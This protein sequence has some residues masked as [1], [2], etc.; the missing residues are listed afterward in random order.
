MDTG[1]YSIKGPLP[2]LPT[3]QS[4]VTRAAAAARRRGNT[5]PAEPSLEARTA[6]TFQPLIPLSHNSAV[7]G[8]VPPH[9]AQRAG[10]PAAKA[11][12][13][14]KHGV[15]PFAAASTPACRLPCVAARFVRSRLK[16]QVVRANGWLLGFTPL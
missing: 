7:C 10:Q 2:F 6:R 11:R 5:N 13:K 4:E 3:Y 8:E 12:A 1:F 9:A 16:M 15:R 14:G